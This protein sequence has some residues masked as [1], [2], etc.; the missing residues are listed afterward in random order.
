MIT[1][2]DRLIKQLDQENDRLEQENEHY[3]QMVNGQVG[4]PN[5]EEQ[6]NLIRWQLD[7]KDDL[8]RLKHLLK[9]DEINYDSKGNVVFTEPKDKNLIPFNNYGVQAIMNIMSFYI[10]KNT[11][12]SNYDEQVIKWKVHDFGIDLNDFLFNSYEDMMITLDVKKEIESL[13]RKKVIKLKNG[14]YVTAVHYD[15]GEIQYQE[16]GDSVMKYVTE[17]LEDHLKQKI[18]KIPMIHRELVDSVHSAYNR[19]F[20]GGERESLRTART[21]TQVDTL[22]PQVPQQGMGLGV[23][24]KKSWYKPF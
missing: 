16:L 4:L 8:D 14:R 23:P 15:K 11:I 5:V 12:L 9:G 6:D 17:I 1:G 18:K 19:A 10:N 2:D 21:V 24:P 7:L 20:N 13:I 3:K 22:R